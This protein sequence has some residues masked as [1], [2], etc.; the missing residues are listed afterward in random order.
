MAF[1]AVAASSAAARAQAPYPRYAP[2]SGPVLPYYLDYFRPQSGV[3]DQYN[4]FVAPKARLQNQLQNIVQQQRIG[5]QAVEAQIQASAQIRPATAAPTGTAAGFM[6]YSHYYG[7]G[8]GAA[9]YALPGGR[10]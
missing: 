2:P 3:L 10:R 1:I 6:N 8:I 7:S 4:Q 5:F 9:T